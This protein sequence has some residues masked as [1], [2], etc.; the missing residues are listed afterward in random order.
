MHLRLFSEFYKRFNELY[1]KYFPI[2][3]RI[4]K[5]KEL[6]KPW[7]TPS[8]VKCIK[9]RDRLAKKA[10]KGKMSINV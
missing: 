6:I 5:R 1:E 9:I 8:L 10:N 7:V 4:A 3:T 2:K